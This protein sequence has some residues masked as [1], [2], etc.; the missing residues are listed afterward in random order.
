MNPNNE[1]PTAEAKA[2]I[3]R[4]AGVPEHFNAPWHI[5]KDNGAFEKAGF[6]VRWSTVS[7]G[8][9]AMCKALAAKEIDMALVLTEGACADIM[10]GGDH[11]IVGVYVQ[12]PLCWG[13]HVSAASKFQTRQDLKN[14]VKTFLS[15]K[16][17]SF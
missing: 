2:T 9:G 14:Q 10:K 4:V 15:A 3:F 1:S 6:D 11:K 12:S 13:V 8:T 5:A 16:I 17:H 7:T